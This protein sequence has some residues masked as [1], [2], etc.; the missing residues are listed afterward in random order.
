VLA[1]SVNYLNVEYPADYHRLVLISVAAVLTMVAILAAWVP[2][3]RVLRLD[4][5][6]LLRRD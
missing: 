4:V 6:D 5:T 1:S 2:A 3:S